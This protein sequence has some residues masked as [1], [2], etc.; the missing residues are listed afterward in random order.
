MISNGVGILK[1]DGNTDRDS[2]P[3]VVGV[4]GQ[5]SSEVTGTVPIHSTREFDPRSQHTAKMVPHI[6]VPDIR[7]PTLSGNAQGTRAK[8]TLHLTF[9]CLLRKY[10][11]R[12]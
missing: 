10:G 3:D 5:T 2:G 8:T 12:A 7:T 6:P 11:C 4:S 1:W 9:C